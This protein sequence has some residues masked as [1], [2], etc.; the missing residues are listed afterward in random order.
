MLEAPTNTD[1]GRHEIVSQA[2]SRVLQSK[3]FRGSP[4]LQAFLRYTVEHTLDG[5]LADLK[6]VCIGV[7]I[8]GK[9]PSYDPKTEPIV[10]VEA[11]RLRLRLE[12]YYAAE[13][14][15][16]PLRILLPKGGYQA[17]FEERSPEPD[18]EPQHPLTPQQPVFALLTA[19][20]PDQP[21]A[22]LEAQPRRALGRGRTTI[23]AVSAVAILAFLLGVGSV[24]LARANRLRPL[25]FNRV[26]PL[27]SYTGME[28]QPAISHDG[29]Q[30]AFVWGGENGDNYDVYVKLIDV[31]SAIRLTTHPAE[32]LSPQWSPDD[33][34]I[35][36]ERVAENAMGVFVIPALGGSERKITDIHLPSSWRPDAL[37][38][39]MNSTPA[40]SSDGSA[41]IVSDRG[42]SE[43][44]AL[45]LV[46]L[47]GSPRRQLTQPGSLIYDMDAVV[48]HDGRHFAFVRETTNS[49][50]D[51]FLADPDGSH[52]RQITFD[53]R[54]IRGV[55]WA[56]DDRSLIFA[57]NR[58]GADGLW[59]VSV[60][61]GEPIG[62]A[63]KGDEVT[64][65]TM[66]SDGSILAYTAITQNANI[67]RIPLGTPGHPSNPAQAEL[68]LS[69]SGRN[70]SAQYSPDGQWIAFISDR[71]GTWE[72]WISDSEGHHLRQITNFA[73]PVVGTPHWSPD[74]R[75]L[76]FDARPKGRSVIFTIGLD[77]SRP[78][79]VIDDGFEDKKPNWSRDGRHLYY[80]SNRNG[81]SQ[82]WRSGLHG[83]DPVQLTTMECNDSL[84]SSDGKAIY[85]QSDDNGLW[86]L[87]SNGGRPALL[88][89][90]A[91]LRPSRYFD[92]KSHVYVIEQEH[93]MRTLS[94]Y[95]PATNTVTP[96]ALI[97]GK[98]VY[99]TPSLSISP[100]G[101]YALFAQEDKISS[102]I[103]TLHR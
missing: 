97:P 38:V 66:S 43:S 87:P 54:L 33:R 34:Y 25:I 56:P 32:D 51:I 53:Q 49:S 91:D 83:E 11:R 1:A 99:G 5:N 65:P 23:I 98:I 76:V 57:S 71:S 4:R 84:E 31:G 86:R 18:P 81:Q 21:S 42:A 72:L 68:I 73:G 45:Y 102:T 30:V 95:N 46:P 26:V 52:L 74:S 69:S 20:Q 24:L 47:D 3:Q 103:M 35:A 6:E 22:P 44:R 12:E 29:K 79:K 36:F 48:S 62:V 96:V 77:E 9:P 39:Q 80:T 2:L 19:D 55:T 28:L 40:W 90:L 61:G 94:D 101:R 64:T 16:D 27:V 92:V 88:T 67:W 82:L 59:Q 75:H 100:D 14:Q 58:G 50:S 78:L 89:A 93:S 13:G 85:F 37:Q 63:A 60:Q 8:F 15:A 10:R 41:L 17:V 70:H 7:A